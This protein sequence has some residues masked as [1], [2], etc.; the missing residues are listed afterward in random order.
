MKREM[1]FKA[2]RVY[3]GEWVEG[4]LIQTTSVVLKS[5]IVTSA[6]YTFGK[7][8][9]ADWVEVDTDTICQYSGLDD[10]NGNKIW[11]NDIVKRYFPNGDERAVSQIVFDDIVLTLGWHIRD[12]KILFLPNVELYGVGLKQIIG[13]TKAAENTLEVIGNIFDNPEMVDL[14]EDSDDVNN[15]NIITAS[16]L[17]VGSQLAESDGFLWDVVEVVKE[18]PKSITVRICSNFSIIK[19]HWKVKPDG[20]PGGLIKTFRKS[21]KIHGIA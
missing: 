4:Y 16:Q 5:F 18:T 12:I 21:S 11:E 1:L 19:Q 14:N 10:K 8:N 7:W 2:K 9:W 15:M 3:N 13:L 6:S 20:S 17:K